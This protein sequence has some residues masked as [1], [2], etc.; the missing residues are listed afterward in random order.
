[1]SIKRE[2]RWKCR[3][4]WLREEQREIAYPRCFGW[5][6]GVCA[7]LFLV[8]FGVKNMKAEPVQTAL[9]GLRSVATTEM[10]LG[11]SIGKLEF[12]DRF[13]PESVLVFWNAEQKG[14]ALPLRDG[15]L[16]LEKENIALF[17]GK[18]A[19]LAGAEGRVQSVE[20]KDDGF[21]LTVLYDNGLCCTAGPLRG[22]RVAQDERVH[23][24][25][26]L[27]VPF[28]A[29][30]SAQVSLCVRRGEAYVPVSEWLRRSGC[31]FRP[32]WSHCWRRICF[33][34]AETG[35]GWRLRA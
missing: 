29:G 13:V 31:A 11:R 33:W 1:M 23:E 25:A 4:R 20:E 27:A 10:E 2:S 9:A 3:K 35:F 22:V 12:V 24:G 5:Q 15:A 18:G 17:E 30:E 6:L 19:L 26:S 34:G 8:L 7:A 32:G 16:L 21:Y 14:L 28:E